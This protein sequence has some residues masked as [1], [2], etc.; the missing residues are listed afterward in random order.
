MSASEL[1]QWFTPGRLA[2]ILGILLVVSFP[3]VVGGLECFFY[4]DFGNFAFPAAF[5]HQEAFWRGDLPLWNPLHYCGI[6][7]LAQWNTLTLYPPA[8]FYLVFPL[9]WSLPVFCLL[10]WLLGG[11]GMYYLAQRWTGT[12][13]GATIAGVAFA[14]NGVTWHCV[15]LPN[16]LVAL[17]WMPWVLLA[18]D[19]VGKGGSRQLILAALVGAMQMLSGAP[20]IILLTWFCA[21]VLWCRELWSAG[22][23]RWAMTGRMLA[24]PVLVAALAA[25]QLLPFLQLVIHAQRD[26]TFGGV[27]DTQ[28]AIPVSGWMNYFVPMVHLFPTPQGA[29]VQPNQVFFGSYYLGIGTV[30]LAGL[31]AVRV[32]DD[33]L[34]WLG[35]LAAVSI[36]MAMGDH[37][38]VYTLVKRLIPQLGVFRFPVKFTM[39]PVLVGPLLAAAAVGWLM[40]LSPKQWD[41]GRLAVR[42]AG[43]G[44][45]ALIAIIALAAMAA[46]RPGDVPSAMLANAVE[47]ALFLAAI[48]FCVLGLGRTADPRRWRWRAL[49]LPL[50]CWF[51]VYTHQ[52]MVGA[53]ISSGVYE[54]DTVREHFG[55]TNTLHAGESRALQSLASM[56]RLLAVPVPDTTVD[57]NGRRLAMYSDYN[58]LD[59]IPKVDG[60][61]SL[62]PRES[63]EVI[64]RLY[65]SRE[66]LSALEDFLGVAQVSDPANPVGWVARTNFM[67]LVSIGQEPKPAGEQEILQRVTSPGFRPREEVWL[68][69]TAGSEVH[70]RRSPGARVIGITNSTPEEW[71]AEVESPAPAMVVIAQTHY[72]AWHAEVDGQPTRLWPANHAFQALE[73]PA[74]HHQVRLIYRDGAL[75]VGVVIS[76]LALVACLVV[77]RVAGRVA[78]KAPAVEP[79]S[80]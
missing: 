4:R 55:W 17:G 67:P 66:E 42:W 58:A 10:H 20:E 41:A 15:S 56:N 62:Y 36:V 39:L 34:R 71:T 65:T 40:R 60:S 49:A 75:R 25:A 31:A 30:V 2:A 46:P 59:H 47:R 6:P 53:S 48:L 73:V 8:L 38:G 28:G 76:L 78:A 29:W 43:G 61:Y 21:G 23:A 24:V 26:A 35:V 27:G 19:A 68:P 44:G 12:R 7:F 54:P 22:P 64:A 37:A 11:V 57:F 70:V 3:Q 50:L 80:P 13:L 51:D 33:R 14:F 63:Q 72:P 79:A 69:L 32:R 9:T 16:Y 45:I 1:E 77:G 18:A 5:F 52:P 74:G